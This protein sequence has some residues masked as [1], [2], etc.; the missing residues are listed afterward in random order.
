MGQAFSLATPTAG[1]AGIDVPEMMDFD[2]DKSMGNAQF[3][4][5]IRAR[6]GEDVVVIKALVKPYSMSLQEYSQDI[7]SWSRPLA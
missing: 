3:M 1:S 4:K 2:Y 6:H 5:T 7:I